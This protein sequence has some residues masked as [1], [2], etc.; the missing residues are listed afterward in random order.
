VWL[1]AT[2]DERNLVCHTN[3]VRLVRKRDV[4]E[5]RT[6]M[7]QKTSTKNSSRPVGG[8]DGLATGIDGSTGTVPPPAPR[9]TPASHMIPRAAEPRDEGNYIG[10]GDCIFY[11]DSNMWGLVHDEMGGTQR[12]ALTWPQRL[13]GRLR[14][15][16]LR[17]VEAALCR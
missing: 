7:N 13:E 16:G 8:V 6:A 4:D 15:S 3:P 12:Y 9:T 11:G 17:M 5:W 2:L 14:D 10:S 1:S